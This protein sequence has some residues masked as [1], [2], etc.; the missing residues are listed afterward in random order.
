MRAR[1]PLPAR[2]TVYRATSI[3]FTPRTVRSLR[4]S[5]R[6]EAGGAQQRLCI[7]GAIVDAVV[8]ATKA[9]ACQPLRE[10][11]AITPQT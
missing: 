9:A 6:V 7:C 4:S 3:G 8:A 2:E 1:Y 11:R 5:Q 10:N